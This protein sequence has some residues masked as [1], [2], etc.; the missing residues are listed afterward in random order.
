MKTKLKVRKTPAGEWVID[1]YQQG[2]TRPGFP[3][4]RTVVWQKTH[5][6]DDW[7]SARNYAV[8][9]AYGR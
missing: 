8:R 4:S 9:L 2:W 7:D 1:V 3:P 6:F 5:W